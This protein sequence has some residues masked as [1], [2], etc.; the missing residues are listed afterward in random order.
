MEGTIGE[1][2]MFAGTF[3]PMDW[4]I[5]NGQTLPLNGYT[6]L[7]AII[8]TYYGGDGKST[9]KLPDLQGR[10]I[11][12]AGQGPGLSV[13]SI[14]DSEG[15]ES[16]PIGLPQ[17][18]AHTHGLTYVPAATGTATLTIKASAND[19]GDP[20]PTGNFLGAPTALSESMYGVP[21]AGVQVAPMANG[22]LSVG[23]VTGPQL[24]ALSMAITG[25]PAPAIHENRQPS[26][27]LNYV[28]C[29]LGN[30]PAR[31]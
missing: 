31:N 24:T 15:T 30:F 18:S 8:G 26:L 11:V 16:V 13:Y 6:A 17:M 3:A 23:S 7:Y 29:L 2:R 22:T 20:T 12:G 5:C 1:V 27:A 14:G 28:I 19:S 4:A 25:N 21:Q 9:F 10:T